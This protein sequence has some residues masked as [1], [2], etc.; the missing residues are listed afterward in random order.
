MLGCLDPITTI[1]AALAT[2]T[3]F[4]APLD[5]REAADEAKAH[6]GLRCC[7][8][9]LL[10]CRVVLLSIDD[11]F[12]SLSPSHHELGDDCLCTLVS[13]RPRICL[14]VFHC[15]GCGACCGLWCGRG[16]QA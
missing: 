3:P 11:C 6:F 10:Y 12:L 13:T 8:V 1:A 5:K 16:W 9:V 7:T 2:R 15:C 4:V 14:A